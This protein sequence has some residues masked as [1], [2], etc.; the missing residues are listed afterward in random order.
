M[1]T[2]EDPITTITR[3]T[4]SGATYRVVQLTDELAI[5]ELRTCHGEPA[6]RLESNDPRC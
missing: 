3:W 1:K 4:D 6:G 5:V 2:Q